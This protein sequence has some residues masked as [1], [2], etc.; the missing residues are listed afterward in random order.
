MGQVFGVSD[1]QLVDLQKFE[2]VLILLAFKPK[3]VDIHLLNEYAKFFKVVYVLV[4][5]DL[6]NTDHRQSTN[7]RVRL[8]VRSLIK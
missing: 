5:L 1:G 4:R 6:V 8:L 7:R 2:F 3:R